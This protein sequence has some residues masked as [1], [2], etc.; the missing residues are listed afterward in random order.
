MC[1]K[2]TLTYGTFPVLV[3]TEGT[4]HRTATDIITNAK[5]EI[6]RVRKMQELEREVNVHKENCKYLRI[7]IKQIEQKQEV[8]KGEI[9]GKAREIEAQY[10]K[11]KK[12]T[13]K[14]SEELE[15]QKEMNMAYAETFH[16]KDYGNYYDEDRDEATE[17]KFKEA[18]KTVDMLEKEKKDITHHLTQ[19]DKEL[20]T[21]KERIH[22]IRMLV[23]PNN[24]EATL[25]E[26]EHEISKAVEIKD[27]NMTKEDL[28]EEIA[29]IKKARDHLETDVKSLKRDK[30]LIEFELRGAIAQATRL[31]GTRVVPRLYFAGSQPKIRQ[32]V[33]R[34]LP[35]IY[36]FNEA[37][38]E[39]RP[40]TATGA[41]TFESPAIP[42]SV[43]RAHTAARKT[44]ERTLYCI[45]CRKNVNTLESIPCEIHKN[46][47]IRGKW[48]CCSKIKEGRGC[49]VATHCYLIQSSDSKHVIITSDREQKIKL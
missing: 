40:K 4:G 38:G 29:G 12:I 15:K 6:P 23:F 39:A 2:D 17:E 9:Q 45:L 28:L 7:Q 10:E 8:E 16:G 33:I 48:T 18:Q 41:A 49:F 21:Y 19:K 34:N 31:T 42:M 27:L 5:T 30:E 46:A 11:L 25:D 44:T 20:Q 35:R 36:P 3:K 1:K 43:V 47:L 26:I 14:L 13:K 32:E 37:D 24:S 22:K